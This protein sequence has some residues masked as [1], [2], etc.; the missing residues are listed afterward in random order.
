MS[1]LPEARWV[2]AVALV[3]GCA[4]PKAESS[5]P[6]PPAVSG[7][8]PTATHT[9]G[10]VTVTDL[11]LLTGFQGAFQGQLQ[12]GRAIVASDFDLD[13]RV[14]FYL[15]NPGDFSNVL[16]NVEG[17][18]GRP[19]FEFVQTL[20]EGELAW[21]GAG[22]D[23]DNDGDT[24]LFITNGGNEGIGFNRL[25]RNEFVERGE[26]SFTDVS[27]AAGITGPVPEGETEPIPVASGNAAVTDYDRDG[28][29]DVFISVNLVAESAFSVQICSPRAGAPSLEAEA[30]R[31]I[32]WR[33]EGNGTFQ[34]VTYEVGLAD[35]RVATRN[36]SWL[37]AD[38]DGD[39]DLFL[40]NV[41]T[42]N[43]VMLNQL[44]ETGVPTFTTGNQLLAAPGHDLSF[45][46]SAVSTAPHDLNQ[47]G[48]MDLLVFSK[49]SSQAVEEGSPYLA[50]HALWL[51]EPSGWR[52]VAQET[53]ILDRFHDY[54]P[55]VMGSQIGDL[56]LDGRPDIYVGNGG[57]DTGTVDVLF[58]STGGPD[59]P[60]AFVPATRLTDF[61][62]PRQAG[63][64]YPVYPYRTHGTVIVDVDN[65]GTNELAVIEGGPAVEWWAREPNRLFEFDWGTAPPPFVKVKLVGDG[66]TV[67]VDAIGSRVMVHTAGE[68][69]RDFHE[70]VQVGHGFSAH[71]LYDL[72]LV[73]P[74]AEGVE[75][76]EVTWTD[77]TTDVYDELVAFGDRVVITRGLGLEIDPE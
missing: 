8:E 58:I 76:I 52:N 57:V 65:N 18:D 47:D 17:P 49:A 5:P 32:L 29:S 3:G 2:L 64:E 6:P 67:P 25:F 4:A 48:R 42:A 20:V 56:N 23:Y 14:D 72:N 15:G 37:D 43:E 46:L 70:T 31:D 35:A 55:G 11:G 53:G 62:A 59:D 40:S 26:L 27:E 10:E 61:E 41:D 30:G 1:M 34:D 39:Q 74:G 21:G 22:L 63:L 75:W 7:E 45:P 68:P 36:S 51:N 54:Q 66:L 77:G 24:D 9:F 19:R 28:D 33:N 60:L 73:L 16:R 50:G 71:V 44:V 13:G 69:S 12:H 38:A